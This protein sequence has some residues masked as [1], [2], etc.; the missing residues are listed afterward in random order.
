MDPIT[1]N[2]EGEELMTRDDIP[3]DSHLTSFSVG[4]HSVCDGTMRVL[5]VSTTHKALVCPECYLRISFPQ[6]IDTFRKLRIH[7]LEINTS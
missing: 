6:D 4:R 2:K 1:L 5:K 7:L 3:D